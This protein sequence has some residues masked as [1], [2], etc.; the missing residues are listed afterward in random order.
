LKY[1]D[2]EGDDVWLAYLDGNHYRATRLLDGYTEAVCPADT[3]PKTLAELVEEALRLCSQSGQKCK[4]AAAEATFRWQYYDDS[5]GR[6]IPQ[7]V[8]K[9]TKLYQYS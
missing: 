3:V 9:N 7:T 6:Q 2:G 1:V 5:T 4:P 8:Q